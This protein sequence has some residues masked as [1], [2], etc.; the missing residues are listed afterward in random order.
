MN[1]YSDEM[2][3]ELLQRLSRVFC[4]EDEDLEDAVPCTTVYHIGGQAFGNIMDSD[5]IDVLKDLLHV[6]Y[7]LE[8]E[9]G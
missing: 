1:E 8:E 6:K 2:L 3:L 5:T 7:A 4:M 9:I